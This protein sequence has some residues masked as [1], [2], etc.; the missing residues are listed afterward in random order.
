MHEREMVDMS[1]VGTNTTP[2]L[3]FEKSDSRLTPPH[4]PPKSDEI[5]Y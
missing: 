4:P 3:W 2:K 1:G 5:W